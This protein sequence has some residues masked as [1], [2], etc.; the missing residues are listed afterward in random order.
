MTTT[1]RRRSPG[2]IAA[3]TASVRAES[4]SS[5]TVRCLRSVNG[6]HVGP[7]RGAV[8]RMTDEIVCPQC[9]GRTWEHLGP[10]RIECSFCHGRGVVGGPDDPEENPPAPPAVPP[11]AWE[12]RIWQDIGMIRTLTCRY[13]LGAKTVSHYDAE[14]QTLTVLPC[15]A[16]R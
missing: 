8:G 7:A 5:R 15:P 16:C 13:C 2:N 10:L 14:R 4:G 9:E 1:R 11:P 3:A 6:W 12:H